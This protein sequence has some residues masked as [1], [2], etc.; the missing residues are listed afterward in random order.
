VSDGLPRIGSAVI[1]KDELNRILLGRRAKDPQRGSWIL[2][3]GKIRAFETI[4]QAAAREMLE[5][6]GLVVDVQRQFRVYEIVNPP[7]EHRIVI[8]SWAKVLGGTPQASDDV[9]ELRFASLQELGHL[10]LTPLVRRVLADAGLIGPG[11]KPT[12]SSSPPAELL[13]FPML[14]AGA[15]SMGAHRRRL[16]GKRKKRVPHI[17]S[18]SLL[19][20]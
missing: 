16:V 4:A 2:P 15:H 10:P 8:Y 11:E 5:E 3:G 9:S 6:T 7:Q 1:V 12:H 20:E 18:S 14:I 17:D 19:F 13:L